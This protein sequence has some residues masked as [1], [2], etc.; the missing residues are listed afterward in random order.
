MHCNVKTVDAFNVFT[1]LCME[2]WLDR[3]KFTTCTERTILKKRNL[4]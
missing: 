4:E 2:S 1:F 3:L